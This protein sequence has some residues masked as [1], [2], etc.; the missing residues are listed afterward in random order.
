MFDLIT[1]AAPTKHDRHERQRCGQRGHQDRREPFFRSTEHQ[2]AAER[3]IFDQFE[4][5]IVAHEHD[6]VSR[7]DADDGDESDQ[8]SE[9]EDAAS[10]ERRDDGADERKRQRQKYERRQS[11][12][13]KVGQQDEEDGDDCANAEQRQSRRGCLSFGVL[14]EDLGVV[15]LLKRERRQLRLDVTCDR[16]EVSSSHV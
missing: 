3:N 6:A 5:S 2:V 8:R 16:S 15:P 11:S 7:G 14:A 12:A 9:R 10:Q 13:A 4:V 1:R